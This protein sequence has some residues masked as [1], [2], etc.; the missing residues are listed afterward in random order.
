MSGF[1]KGYS[2]RDFDVDNGLLQDMWKE[3]PLSQKFSIGRT[4]AKYITEYRIYPYVRESI[5]TLVQNV[6]FFGLFTDGSFNE[7]LKKRANRLH[8]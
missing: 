6:S 1:K 7:I 8:H 5:H 4:K 3:D 2:Y